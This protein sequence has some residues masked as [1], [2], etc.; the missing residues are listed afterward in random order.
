MEVAVAQDLSDP[1]A[2]ALLDPT[3][4]PA[5]SPTCSTEGIQHFCRF[6]IDESTLITGTWTLQMT[7]SG[8]PTALVYRATGI[9]DNTATFD[10]NIVSLTGDIIEYPEPMLLLVTLQRELPIA[11][12]VVTATLEAPDGTLQP[13]TLLDNGT[14]PDYE[15]HDGKYAALLRYD[16]E[17]TYTIHARFDNSAGTAVETFRGVALAPD[18]TGGVEEPD[19][20]PISEHFV[21]TAE[22]QVSITGI[23]ADDHG[24]V[25]QSATELFL[26]D[27][28]TPGQIDSAGDIDLFRVTASSTDTLVFRVHSLAMEMLPQF[29]LLAEDGV[30]ELERAEFMPADD[31]PYLWVS[32]DLQPDT[33]VY[34]E[35]SHRD[36]DAETGL[37]EVSAGLPLSGEVSDVKTETVFLPLIQR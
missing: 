9:A 31:K 25:P 20:I 16:Q 32:H 6:R 18:E 27:S 15:A 34:I 35:I 2:I 30:T 28:G 11:G 3:G 26:N 24:D 8:V 36:A 13:L 12:A 17:G 5:N 14:G 10:A 19:P 22:K 21:R 7:G 33:T 4:T 37:Y 1:A 23:Q 29:R